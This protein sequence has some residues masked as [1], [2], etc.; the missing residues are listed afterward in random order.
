MRFE[1]KSD[2]VPSHDDVKKILSE[3]ISVASE[4]IRTRKIKG[5]FGTKVFDVHADVYSS[6]KEFDRVVKKTKQELEKEK[7]AIE[8]KKKAETETK[9]AA[10]EAKAKEVPVT[11]KPASEGKPAEE[12]KTEEK[13]E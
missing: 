12:K 2:G 4:L 13:K 8:E 7:K 10:E 5:K 6:K 11:E 1:I 9:K 3:K